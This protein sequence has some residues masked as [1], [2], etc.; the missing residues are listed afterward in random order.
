MVVLRHGPIEP[1]DEEPRSRHRRNRPTDGERGEVFEDEGPR[2][3][4]IE[5]GGSISLP[6]GLGVSGLDQPGIPRRSSK[7]QSS[8]AEHSRTPSFSLAPPAEQPAGSSRLPF[9]RSPSDRRVSSN[10]SAYADD[11]EYA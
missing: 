3:P 5:S 1:E 7:R 8:T 2:V 11:E 6:A 10:S 4:G 9:E